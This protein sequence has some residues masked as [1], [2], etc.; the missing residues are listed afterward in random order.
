MGNVAGDQEKRGGGC[1]VAALGAAVLVG[2][3]G[4]YVL[5]AGPAYTHLPRNTFYK[6]YFPLLVLDDRVPPF[7]N[8][9]RWYMQFWSPD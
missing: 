8:L 2:L 6:V 1:A 9:L 5:S 7:A 3:I 4:L